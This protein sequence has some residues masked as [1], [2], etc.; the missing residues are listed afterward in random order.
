MV[1]MWQLPHGKRP[2]ASTWWTW[3]YFAP[4][5]YIISALWCFSIIF[6]FLYTAA[7]IFRIKIAYLEKKLSKCACVPLVL[8]H[9]YVFLSAIFFTLSFSVQPDPAKPVTM[10]IH[11]SPYVNMK[12]TFA[13]LQVAVVYFGVKVSWKGLNLPRWLHI[14]SVAHVVPL[15]IVEVAG[16]LI[17]INALA[18]MG[19]NLEGNGLWWSV[20]TE[21]NKII[22]QWI[23]NILAFVLHTVFP[24]FQS[25]YICRN[26]VDSHALIVAVNDNR[27]SAYST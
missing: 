24:L 20:R 10:L 27:V 18:D 14:M 19:E 1:S 12:I 8:A 26:G 2:V 11:T 22:A 5:T 9:V 21:A 23:G 4:T 17:L 6:I 16:S 3:F 15:I 7:A 13:V 25:L